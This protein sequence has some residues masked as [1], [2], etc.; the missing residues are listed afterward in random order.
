[1]SIVFANFRFAGNRSIQKIL[2]WIWVSLLT[3][4][5]TTSWI[6]TAIS[7][8]T[9][10]SA[11]NPATSVIQVGNLLSEP[12]TLDGYEL[13]RVAVD[14]SK[15]GSNQQDKKF[16]SLLS[17][18]VKRIQNE[19][20]AILDNPFYGGWLAPGF[21]RETLTVKVVNSK[22]NL[23]IVVAD[24][25]QLQEREILAVTSQD[26]EYNGY[27]LNLWGERIAVIIKEALLRGYEQRTTTY[28][29][30]NGLIAGAI[31]L[32]ATLVS[33]LIR[34]IQKQADAVR[35][36]LQVEQLRAAELT[37]ELATDGGGNSPGL[38][39][40]SLQLKSSCQER[41]NENRFL[42]RLLRIGQLVLWLV[43]LWGVLGLFAKTRWLSVWLSREPLYLGIIFLITIALMRVSR[44]IVDRFIADLQAS[45]LVAIKASPRH[46]F[47]FP[48]YAI[49]LKGLVNFAWTIVGIIVTLD[50]LN[51]PVAPL[52]AGIGIV[53]LALSFGSQ[54]LVKDV[55]NGSFI[56]L[57]DQYAVGDFIRVGDIKGTVEYMNLRITQIRG[58]EGRL[59]TFPNGTIQIVHNMTKDWARSDFEIEINL[60]SDV[61]LAIAL[62]KE[63]AETMQQ[64]SEWAAAILNPVMWIGASNISGNGVTIEMS[65]KTAFNKRV[66]VG[67]E[68]RRRLKMAFD[69]NNIQF[70][71]PQLALKK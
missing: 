16:E 70:G 42:R 56:L 24:G 44:S 7:Q 11:I 10:P 2:N 21:T 55:I 62:M 1:M 60:N 31:L 36:Q 5:L 59:T 35:S 30:K 27:P 22:D 13:F 15:E 39:E 68:F 19:L 49:V 43:A 33:F 23:V 69:A 12:I 54:N 51:I 63:I 38:I 17:A 52:L 53:G 71:V 66:A 37:G 6:P 47:R 32:G 61:N 58:S 45:D 26:A 40:E 57:E 3:M 65:I 9:L 28:L 8:Q 46:K 34:R 14:I 67:Y 29:L 18:R 25:Q 41:R 48:T 64:E 4:L 20:Y 50:T